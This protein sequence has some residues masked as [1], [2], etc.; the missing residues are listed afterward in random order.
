MLHDILICLVECHLE[1]HCSDNYGLFSILIPGTS[2]YTTIEGSPLLSTEESRFRGP[3]LGGGGNPGLAPLAD[4]NLQAPQLY[5]NN[6]G[7]PPRVAIGQHIP[8]ARRI[9]VDDIAA[10]TGRSATR[11]EEQ[12]LSAEEIQKIIS[13]GALSGHG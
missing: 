11:Y 2:F 9:F 13:M 5:Y 12:V 1:Y 10:L 4:S 8:N 3:A 7:Q 6:P